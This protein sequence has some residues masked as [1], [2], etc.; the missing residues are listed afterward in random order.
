MRRP[1][2]VFLFVLAV[3]CLLAPRAGAQGPLGQAPYSS[4]G[5]VSCRTLDELSRPSALFSPGDSLVVQGQG[6]PADAVI[7]VSFEQEAT[8]DEEGV[9]STRLASVRP[10]EEGAYTTAE[11][12]TKI[13]D[14]ARAG[15][16]AIRATDG[17]ETTTCSIRIVGDD[18]ILFDDTDGIGSVVEDGTD[19]AAG[20][21]LAPWA[22]F[23]LVFGGFLAFVGVRRWRQRRGDEDDWLPE[24]A[25]LGAGV[26]GDED[27]QDD[28]WFESDEEFAAGGADDD[29]TEVR[30]AGPP[31]LTEEEV[32]PPT[33]RRRESMVDRLR[34]DVQDWNPKD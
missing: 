25:F 28:D 2:R 10:D 30:P 6:F 3:V 19:D 33:P 34:K 21:F 5:A 7:R 9:D 17:Q 26:D 29:A 4:D 20:P 8:G 16:A 1:Q 14:D 32:G 24:E 22:A 13:P 15:G 27:G 12:D 31:L 23:L 18:G 11:R